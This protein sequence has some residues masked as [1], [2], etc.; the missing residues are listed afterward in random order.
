[1]DYDLDDILGSL[2]G[3]ILND[4]DPK[5]CIEEVDDFLAQLKDE[6]ECVQK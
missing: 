6:V 1:M 4:E 2:K 3:W 5:S